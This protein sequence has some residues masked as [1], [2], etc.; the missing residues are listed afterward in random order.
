MVL[1]LDSSLGLHQ[2]IFTIYPSSRP[3]T[4]KVQGVAGYC[5]SNKANLLQIFGPQFK[6]SPVLR[7][8]I[9][10]SASL[11]TNQAPQ[12]NPP[13]TTAWCSSCLLSSSSPARLPSSSNSCVTSSP[14]LLPS[15]SHSYYPFLSMQFSN[16]G[17]TLDSPPRFTYFQRTS[18][19]SSNLIPDLSFC[20][21]ITEGR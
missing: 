5:S 2:A 7:P 9:T 18:P 3:N 20:C 17:P 14:L 10:R 13:L 16:P 4:D 8:Q 12:P 21:S 11:R 19:S 1:A 6:K 15:P